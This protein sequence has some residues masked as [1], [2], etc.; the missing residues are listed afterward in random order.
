MDVCSIN[1]ISY[2]PKWFIEEEIQT[3]SA[4]LTSELFFQWAY[5]SKGQILPAFQKL[6][7]NRIGREVVPLPQRSTFLFPRKPS[8]ALKTIH[9]LPPPTGWIFIG[10]SHPFKEISYWYQKKERNKE[11]GIPGSKGKEPYLKI[12]RMKMICY[13]RQNKIRISRYFCLAKRWIREDMVSLQT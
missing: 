10:T 2:M 9:G 5:S 1:C 7:I 6:W 12:K 11:R 13:K 4:S 8:V 3:I